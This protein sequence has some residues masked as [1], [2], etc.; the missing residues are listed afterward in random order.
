MDE[1]VTLFGGGGFLGRYVAR[2]LLAGGARVRIVGRDPK[3]A[4]FLK[5]Q[6]GLGQT[7]FVAADLRKPDSVRRAV[8]GSDAVVNLV[9]ILKGD[10]QG[11]H[12]DGARH[13]AEA[14]AGT[15]ARALVQVSALGADV[16][17]RSAYARS[18][19]LG[20]QAVREA[21][22]GA[23]IIRPSIVFG[24]ED[25]FVNMF[26]RMAQLLPLLPIIRGEAKFQPIWVA[27][28]ARAIAAAAIEPGLHAGKTYALGGPEV[29]TMAAIN[30]WVQAAIGRPARAI[31]LPDA[32]TRLMASV[33]RFL[34]GAPITP[35]QF[36]M[37]CTDNVVPADASGIA[38]FGIVPTPLAVI[39]P[40]WL[41]QFRRNGR[42]AAA[43]PSA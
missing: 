22:P 42:F 20:E 33:G 2:A 5:P 38:A 41:V 21:F 31:E 30:R 6:G 29:L 1:L 23:T 12:V 25:N 4:W 11:L 27:D 15:G 9:G 8:Q 17:S 13:V 35:D 3:R 18:K 24:R 19:A 37:L 26:A 16:A 14:A 28:A 40:S 34:P 7:Q 43:R 36:E 10:F 32:A 39:A